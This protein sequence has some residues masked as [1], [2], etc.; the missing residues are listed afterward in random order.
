MTPSFD[1]E[2]S[3]Y[4]ARRAASGGAPAELQSSLDWVLDAAGIGVWEYDHAADRCVWNAHLCSLMGHGREMVPAG[5]QAWLDLIHPDDRP[6][7]LAQVEATLLAHD[8]RLYEAEYRLRTADGRW[9][10]FNARG[11]VLRRDAA[12]QALLTAGTMIDISERK[13]AELLLQTQH[14]FAG[15]LALGPDRATLL[16]QILD[17]ALCLPEL[18]GGGLYWREPDGGYR[19]LVERGLSATFL[20]QVR[21]LAAD[22]PQAEVIREGRLRCSCVPPQDFCTDSSLVARPELIEEGIV[23]LLVLPIHVGGEPVACLNLAS[24]QTGAVRPLTLT[25]LETL[26]RQF[27]MALEN[28]Q[29]QEKA[30][31]QWHDLEGLF[32]AITDHVFV[33]DAQGRI[34]F[35]N[36]AVAEGLGYGESLLGQPVS[37]VHPPEA[38]DECR[39]VVA[40]IFAGAGGHCSLPLRKA[41]GTLVAVDTRV[42]TGRW[43]GRPALIGVARDVTESLRQQKAL[44]RSEALLRATLDSTADGILVV[45]DDGSVLNVNRRFQDT[46]RVPEE[47]MAAGQDERLL[48]HVLDQ[49]SQP[50]AFLQDVQTLYRSDESRWD[51]LEFRDGRVFER[52]TRA[53]PLDGQRARLWSFRDVTER[54]GAQRALELERAHLRTLIRTIPDLVWLKDPQGVYLAC[55]PAFER[56][57]AA[58]EAEIVGRSDD[59]FV[60]RELAEFFRANDRAAVTA[61]GPRVNE[62]WLTFAADGRRGLFETIKT[63]M[64]ASDGRLIGILGIAHDITE[65]RATQESLREREELYRTIVNEAAEAID[66]VDAQTLCFAE[67]GGGACRMLGYS[68]EELLGMPLAVIEANRGEAEIRALCAQVLAAGSACFDTRH[69]CKDGRI[70]DVQVS[71]RVIRLHGRDYFLAIWRDVGE[72]KRAETALRD[73]TMF[74]RES[75]AI[76]RVGGWKA[77]PLTNT[78]LWTDEVFWLVEHPRG[79]PPA[80]LEEG[81]RYYAPECRDTVRQHLQESWARGTTFRLECEMI[82]ASGRR[83]WAELRCVGRAE[84]H[85]ETFLTGT[86]QDISERRQVA[87]ELEQHRHHLEELVAERTARLEAANRRLLISDLRLKAMFDM[88]QQAERL[89]ERELLQRGIEEAVRLTE[90]EIGYLH[91]VNEDQET[92][93]LYTWSAATLKHCTAAYDS[94][95]PISMAGVWA[96]TAR[97][98][99]AVVHN[100]YQSLL[101]RQGYPPGHA[102]LIRHLGVPIIENDRVRVLFGV[103]NKATDY[104]GSDE[105]E[106]QLIGDDLWRIVMR[107]RADAALA[108][109][110]NAAEAA[111]RAKSTFL[112][113]MSH[114][115]RTPLNA[116]LGMTYLARRRA[117]DPKLRQQLDKIGA[118]ADHLLGV[119]NDVLDLSKIE[120]GQFELDQ[121][122]FAIDEIV[123]P[124]LVLIG[125]GARAKGLALV[126]EVDPLLGRLRGDSLRLGQILIN[127]AGNAVKFTDRGSITLRVQAL[128]ETASGWQVR[129]EVEDTGPGIEPMEQERLFRDFEQGDS[130]TTRQF[131]GTGLG[132]SINRRLVQLMGGTL[133][134]RSQP[135]QGSTFWFVVPLD[136]CHGMPP[137]AADPLPE[138]SAEDALAQRHRGARLLLAEDNPIN[139]EV[140]LGLLQ[141]VGLLVDVAHDGAEAVDLAR[142]TA[143]DLILMDVQMPVL[144]GLQATRSIRALAGREHVPI[145]AM[146]A[147]AFEEDRRRC[148]D[149]GMNDHVGKPVEPEVLFATILRWLS[150]RS[151]PDAAADAEPAAEVAADLSQRL[152]A[153]PGFDPHLGLERVRG[154]SDTYLRLLR[155]FAESGAED[156]GELRRCLA[157]GDLVAA[158]RLAHSL[159]GAAGALGAVHVQTLAAELEEALRTERSAAET[160]RRLAEVEAAQGALSAALRAALPAAAEVPPADEDWPRARSALAELEALL[161]ADDMRAGDT[162]RSTAP[163]LQAALGIDAATKLGRDIDRFDYERA[164]AILREASRN[165]RSN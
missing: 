7:V 3:G 102:H 4:T 108:V 47:L 34:L 139:Q 118:A 57:F 71:V 46:W 40:G 58:S 56:L 122:E 81:L 41:D 83:F 133:G 50:E 121:S 60:A 54:N 114:E 43:N 134:V 152:A 36:A 157:A 72:Q 105:R 116:I 165:T 45:A 86:F 96:D 9:I 52:F 97:L 14:D 104:D 82:A 12:G 27:T 160:G 123:A 153:I 143:Y 141:E 16:P 107:R 163:L 87:A 69:R 10:W 63:P 68:R 95:Y 158:R 18:D 145:L 13:H 38:R 149:A 131:G 2:L 125:D 115:I 156:G 39:R 98:R 73:A 89:S 90:S 84:H 6:A 76:A 5:M 94:H 31:S 117:S 74:L 111:S 29:S 144:D 164:L 79:Q 25:A 129:F 42:A 48:G 150:E 75:E 8:A 120:A 99:R 161:S 112:A 113:N 51:I 135:G 106:L 20:A 92:I 62:E 70:L 26:A 64:H 44:Q 11:R 19:L 33:L 142:R 78:V 140:T 162:F 65:S 17:S 127:F 146:T 37:T 32:G 136:K 61:G 110:K 91:L 109:A 93:Q 88:S 49:L 77:N 23:S 155:R 128:E 24:R 147:N 30:A 103:G 119:V 28:L 138:Q 53:F 124:V 126:S 151:V 1:A 130:S 137:P 66:L 100:D 15:A 80:T 148:L 59:D 35:Y 67:V 22:S 55:N 85:G 21:H 159:R 154:R 101:G 132:L